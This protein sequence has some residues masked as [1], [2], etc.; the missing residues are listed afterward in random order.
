MV[1]PPGNGGLVDENVPSLKRKRKERSNQAVVN[2][3]CHW[4]FRK[5][6]TTHATRRRKSSPLLTT[7]LV[8]EESKETVKKICD[9]LMEDEIVIIGIYGMGGVGKTAILMHIHNRVL[10]NPTFNDV[11]WVTVPQEFSIYEL[12]DEIANIVGLDNLSKVKDVKRRACVLNGHLKKKKRS[13]LLLD[14]MWVHFEVEDVGIPIEQGG[15]KVVLTTRSLDVCHKMLCQKQVKIKPLCWGDDP[16]NLFLEKLCFEKEITSEVEEIARSI[17]DECGGLPLCIIEIATHMRGVEKVHEWKGMLRKLTESGVELNVFKTL[18]LSYMNLGDSR[19][20]QCFLHSMLCYGEYFYDT[21]YLIESF[22]DED[23]LGGIA[24]RQEQHNE[25]DIILDKIRKA[26]L[27]D[28]GGEGGERHDD[29]DIILD[30]IRKACLRDV[31]GEG[32]EEEGGE[33]GEDWYLGV[34]PLL[35]DMALQI[36]TST[37]HMVKA[38]MGLE[39]IPEE[40]FWTNRLEKVFLQGNEIKKIPYDMSPN[41]PKLTRLSLK[42]NMSLEAI[43][44]S[45]F[46]HLKGLKVLNLSYTRLMELPDTIS[47]LESLEALLL[48]KCEKL[49]HIPCV[50]RL[51]SLR[52]LDLRGCAVLREVPE[53]MEMLVKLTYLDLRGTKIEVLP[54]GVLGKLVNLQYLVINHMMDEEVEVELKIVE[55]LYYFGPNVETFN[56]CVRLVEQNSSQPYDL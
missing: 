19:V 27:R 29:G 35:R 5:L 23:L 17:V 11:F 15:L 37:T 49:C 16:W 1:S 13:I 46:K 34:H 12:Q 45:F 6:S 44:K 4:R 32:G 33:E 14:G 53:G 2:N 55:G 20:Q 42:F 30:K 40:K 47:H 54:E 51:G 10:D 56:A 28:V 24:T 26:C 39:E 50:Q 8:G 52:K 31:G 48:Q 9:Y 36:V 3:Y 18:K 25:G 38:N 21:N 43:P 22:I 41:C 7:K